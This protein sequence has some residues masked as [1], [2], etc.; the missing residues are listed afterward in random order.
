MVVIRHGHRTLGAQKPNSACQRFIARVQKCVAAD[1][2][3]FSFKQKLILIFSIVLIWK[4]APT[5][6]FSG[7]WCS[8]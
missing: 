6:S 5:I 3:F 7:P 4:R 2:I 8:R 1:A